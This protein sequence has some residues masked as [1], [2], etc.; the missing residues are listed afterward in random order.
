MNRKDI[1][2]A[3]RIGP[4]ARIDLRKRPTDADGELE[5]DS[6]EKALEENIERMYKLQHLMYAEDKHAVLIILQGMDTS[7][8]DST[9]RHVMRGMNPMGFTVSSYK[10]PV[11]EEMDHDFLWRVHKAVPRIGEFAIFNRSHYE[12]VIVPKVHKTIAAGILEQRYR[13]INDF[14]RM[15]SENG[16]LILKFFLHISREEQ[17]KRLM[18]RMKDPEKYWKMDPADLAE[19]KLWNRYQKAYVEAIE[20]CSPRHAP[21]Y[22][23]PSDRKWVRNLAVSQIIVEA[24]EALGMSYPK[25]KKGL[26]VSF[27]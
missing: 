1:S 7:G 19:R 4:G 17:K 11:P 3:F 27:D 26:P 10:P 6:G 16:T 9:I 22:V 21:W 2:R 14:E 13:Q 12:D 20:R 8:K 23:I 25:A 18:E 24:L 15:L 5:K